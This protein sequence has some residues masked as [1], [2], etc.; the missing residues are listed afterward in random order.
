MRKALAALLLVACGSGAARP[1]VPAPAPDATARAAPDTTPAEPDVWRVEGALAR[2]ELPAAMPEV[3]LAKRS[4][5]APP[6]GVPPA[7]ASCAAYTSRRAEPPACG[8]R[9]QALAGLEAALASGAADLRDGQLAGLEDCALLP[10]GLARALRIEL[11]PVECADALARPWLASPPGEADGI[12]Y[13]AIF[14]LGLSGMLARTAKGPPPPPQRH[15]KATLHQYVTGPMQ[16]WVTEQ[17]TAIQTLGA[18]GSEIGYYGRAVVAVEAG[19]ADMRFID[20][21]REVPVP[22]EFR[23]DAEL[24]EVY[25]QGLER[26]LEPRKERGRDAALVGLGSLATIG[27]LRDERV[28]RARELLSRL[29]GGA[30]INALDRLLLPPLSQVEAA[31]PEEKLARRLQTFYASLLFPPERAAPLLRMLIERGVAL[32][33]RVALGGQSLGRAE[34]L[35][36]ARARFELAQNYWRRV[37]VDEAIGLLLPGE[38]ELDDTSRLVLATALALHGGPANAAEMMIKAPIDELGIGNVAALDALAARG[39]PLAGEA[40]FNAAYISQLAARA[41]ADAAAWRRIAERYDKAAALLV[42]IRYKRLAGERAAEAVE[43]AQ[44]IETRNR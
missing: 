26:A 22:E 21:V 42:D 8:D 40:A 24:E 44:A 25:Y 27:L 16:R 1:E 33:H 19:M 32:P 4:F 3:A 36:Y 9:N 12:V 5:P 35:L 17:A 23:G 15:D 7:P 11:A 37:D 39:G 43:T 10:A 2:E 28:D 20:A 6:K 31:T 30:P 14:G 41:G 34:R 18:L 38:G 29:Y 13:D